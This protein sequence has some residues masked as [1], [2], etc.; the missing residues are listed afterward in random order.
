LID[1][2]GREGPAHESFSVSTPLIFRNSSTLLIFRAPLNSNRVYFT[3][4]DG[5]PLP[6]GPPHF[7]EP[8]LRG[9]AVL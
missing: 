1:R 7:P 6:I 5:G 8:S 4:Q 3:P 2:T 9:P